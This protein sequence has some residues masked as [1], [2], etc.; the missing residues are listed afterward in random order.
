[1]KNEGKKI[2]KLLFWAA[3]FL[4]AQNT[5]AVTT[6]FQ[7]RLNDVD[8]M[9]QAANIFELN[10]Q[11]KSVQYQLFDID[12]LLSGNLIMARYRD[13][14][15]KIDFSLKIKFSYDEN[16]LQV[17]QRFFPDQ[18]IEINRF[19]DRPQDDLI[20]LVFRNEYKKTD[21]GL[22]K[23]KALA[24]NDILLYFSSLQMHLKEKSKTFVVEGNSDIPYIQDY[25]QIIKEKIE[26]V[27]NTDVCSWENIGSFQK[28]KWTIKSWKTYSEIDVEVTNSENPTMEISTRIEGNVQNEDFFRDL[29]LSGL[30]I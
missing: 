19:S 14:G 28:V 21:I 23:T 26:I 5:S 30:Q 3:L 25:F 16:L 29:R 1:V 13:K 8:K 4:C 12:D 22:D 9:K 2:I 11:S 18:K 7:A 6:E 24:T 15:E 27:S 20:E 10:N 17:L